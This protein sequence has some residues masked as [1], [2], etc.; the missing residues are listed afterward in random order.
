[1]IDYKIHKTVD[2]GTDVSVT[3]RIYD[4]AVTTEN[5]YDLL[6]DKEV[7]VE[8]YRRTAMLGEKTVVY[9]KSDDIRQKLNLVLDAEA[10]KRGDVVIDEQK[11]APS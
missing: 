1:M 6:T 3:Y 11:N 4:G 2:N 9:S 8:R 7:P 10:T 5:E